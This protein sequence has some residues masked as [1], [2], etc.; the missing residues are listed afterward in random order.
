MAERAWWS[1]ALRIARKDL[2]IELRS[3]VV[4]TQII[5]F[6]GILVV[7]FAVAIDPDRQVLGRVAPGLFWVAALLSALLMIDRIYR[8]E[9]DDGLLRIGFEMA[10]IFFGKVIAVFVQVVAVNTVT[11]VAMVALYGVEIR[12][13]P[14]LLAAMLTVSLGIAAFGVLF[15]AATS[16]ANNGSTVLPLLLIPALTPLLIA[17]TQSMESA[18]GGA[19]SIDWSGIRFAFVVTVV[20]LSGGALAY[21]WLVER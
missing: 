12:Q 16:N 6:S 20:A 8:I 14:A 7:L 9:P 19:S 4:R 17:G 15:G 13:L 2:L 21:E 11:G 5:P 10:S 3:G 18:L 1:G